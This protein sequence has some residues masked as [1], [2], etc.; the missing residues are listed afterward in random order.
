[1]TGGEEFWSLGHWPEGGHVHLLSL[2]KPKASKASE[3]PPSVWVPDR[4]AGTSI[5]APSSRCH[6]GNTN[7]MLPPRNPFSPQQHWYQP[8]TIHQS[9][10]LF[11][12]QRNS[13]SSIFPGGRLANLRHSQCTH[14]YLRQFCKVPVYLLSG[15]CPPKH[16]APYIQIIHSFCL[17]LLSFF[18]FF[19]LCVL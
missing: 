13:S 16:H 9:I 19:F 2:V 5:L 1:M 12:S 18:F 3:N 11:S 10:H 15:R 14:A 4:Q 8:R 6:R 7:G 17:C